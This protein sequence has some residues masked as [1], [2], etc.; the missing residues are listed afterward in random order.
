MG[1]CTHDILKDALICSS[2]RWYQ[3][4]S[5]NRYKLGLCF[6]GKGCTGMWILRT[7]CAAAA[8]FLLLPLLAFGG[9]EPGGKPKIPTKSSY[10][11]QTSVISAGGSPGTS[12][13]FST[14][15]TLGQPTPIGVGSSAGKILYAGFWG[16]FWL[17]VPVMDALVPEVFSNMAFQNFPNPFNPST[18][19]EFTVAQESPVELIVFNVG[20]EVVTKLAN[21]GKLPGRYEVTW[22]GTDS[23]GREVSSGVYFY[24]LKIGD[25]KSTKKMLMLK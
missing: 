10:L 12:T 8:V 14:N 4:G 3:T 20:G 7:C 9:D 21:E 23:F 11:L 16:K 15:G 24:R 2:R 6:P 19:I 22:D 17:L 18:T 25:Y 13:N 1:S 5:F